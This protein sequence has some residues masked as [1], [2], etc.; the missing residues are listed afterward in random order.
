MAIPKKKDNSGKKPKNSIQEPRINDEIRGYSEVRL[1]WEED[2]TKHSEVMSITSAR[3]TAAAYELDLIELNANANPPILL[4]ANYSK[5]LYNLK[6]QQKAKAKPTTTVKEVQLST[7]ISEHDMEVKA[8][9]AKEFLL[10]G[11]KVKVT[12]TMRGR[13]LGRREESKRSLFQ[14]ITMLEDV[15]VP[16]AMPRDEG[17]RAIVIIKKKSNIPTKK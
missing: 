4:M 6:R 15:G 13:E 1:N 5:Y 8:K 3:N 12:L 7:N 9:K 14:F 10:D 17:N 16:E 2:G 11:D